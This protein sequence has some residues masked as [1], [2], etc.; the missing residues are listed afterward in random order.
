MTSDLWLVGISLHLRI[1]VPASHCSQL[2]C[3]NPGFQRDSVQSGSENDTFCRFQKLTAQMSEVLCTKPLG[4]EVPSRSDLSAEE[5]RAACVHKSSA[6][7]PKSR[8]SQCSQLL[9]MTQG[10]GAPNC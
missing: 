8:E 4:S 2:V 1:G 10:A 7:P 5:Y 3:T 6:L 9:K